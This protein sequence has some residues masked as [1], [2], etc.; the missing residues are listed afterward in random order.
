MSAD[1]QG[2]VGWN[3]IS[4]SFESNE[5]GSTTRAY[6]NAAHRLTTTE[7]FLCERPTRRLY[8]YDEEQ[9]YYVRDGGTHVEELLREHLPYELN[10]TRIRNITKLV[11]VASYVDP[12]DFRPKPGFVCVE[13]G[14][15]DLTGD[16]PELLNHSPDYR[17]RSGLPVEFDPDAESDLWERSLAEWVPDEDHRRTLQEF[18]GYCLESWHHGHEKNLYIVGPR[19]AGKSTFTEAVLELFGANP[20]TAVS[21]SP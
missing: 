9:G 10:E 18:V 17:F 1:D 19:R 20:P 21:L 16:E 2:A 5:K 3:D 4:L 15:I 6:N 11:R 7:D 13:N 12:E 14:V 8:W